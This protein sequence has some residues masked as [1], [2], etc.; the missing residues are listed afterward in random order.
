MSTYA[1]GD[2]QGCFDQLE[3]LLALVEFDP[4]EDRLWIA[5]D[6]VNRGPQS[7]E[8]L[9]FLKGLGDRC[10][11]VLGNHDLHLLAVANEVMRD[12]R[13]DT[14]TAILEAPDRDELLHWLRHLPLIHHCPR[15]NYTLVHAGIPPI[16][17]LKAAL[18]R[19]AEVESVLRSDNYRKLL[20]NM[21]GDEPA[22]WHKNLKGWARLRVIINYLTRMR[23]CRADGTLNL[24]QK[25]GPDDPPKGFLPWYSHP[26]RKSDDQRILFGHWAA[27]EGKACHPNVFALDTGCVW[28]GQLTAMELESGRLTTLQCPLP[29]F[30]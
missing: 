20:G 16:W 10:I 24:D 26:R 22:C 1:I 9:R 23:F 17:S 5:G 4:D 15:L 19:A 13:Q 7:L 6:L 14:L 21:Y 12:R 29:E 27:L 11:A 28:G 3:D 30:R 2:I 8:T 25:N 18:N